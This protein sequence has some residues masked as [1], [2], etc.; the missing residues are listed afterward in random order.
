VTDP[1]AMLG[2]VALLTA[3]A[4]SGVAS[5]GEGGRPGSIRKFL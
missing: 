3:A 5:A 4:L 1:V 2:V